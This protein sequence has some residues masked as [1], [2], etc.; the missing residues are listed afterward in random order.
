MEIQKLLFATLVIISS[1]GCISSESQPSGHSDVL[2]VIEIVIRHHYD[3]KNYNYEVAYLFVLGRDPTDKLLSRLKDLPIKIYDGSDYE[4][5]GRPFL[6]DVWK[7]QFENSENAWVK[8]QDIRDGF[9]SINY[10]YHLSKIN[11]RWKLAEANI[12]GI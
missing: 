6:F 2:E 12:I 9:F 11:G 3:I 10:E 8:A 5:N 1:K 4:R 7:V